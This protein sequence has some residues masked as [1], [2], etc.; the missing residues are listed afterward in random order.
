M[1]D[2]V[3]KLVS[4]QLPQHTVENYPHREKERER[5]KGR[6]SHL[7]LHTNTN[8]MSDMPTELDIHHFYK[9]TQTY[10]ACVHSEIIQ[11]E[12]RTRT[13]MVA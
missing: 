6:E 3:T 4:H 10:T 8:T 5:E 1:K 2:A 12:M 11:S 9:R 13:E 7:V